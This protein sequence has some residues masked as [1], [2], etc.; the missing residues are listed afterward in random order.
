MHVDGRES[1]QTAGSGQLSDVIIDTLGMEVYRDMI[2]VLP[3]PDSSQRPDLPPIYVAGFTTTPNQT[4]ANR[5]Q[6]ILFI[7][8]RNVYDQRLAYAVVQAYHTLIPQG[9]YPVT[10]LMI[11]L[12]PEEVDVNVHPTKAEV[13]FR[14]PEAVFSSVQ[15]GVRKALLE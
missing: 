2:E 9:R 1:F 11:N 5:S 13:R 8:G 7:N 10:V 4:R 3:L 12:P 15:R 14:S 6:I